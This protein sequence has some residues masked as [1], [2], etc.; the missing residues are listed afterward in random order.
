[1][2]KLIL[3]TIIALLGFSTNTVTAKEKADMAVAV[4]VSAASTQLKGVVFD[5]VTRESLAG[6][7]IELNGTKVYTDLEGNFTLNNVCNGPCEIKINLI[8][9]EQQVV[10]VDA[11][12]VNK[13]NVELSQR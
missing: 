4:E 10:K 5:K 3:L 8:S 2:K 12:K 9:Y 13:L 7:M 6:A 11:S 1:M